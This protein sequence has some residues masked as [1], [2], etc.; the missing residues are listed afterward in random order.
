MPRRRAGSG[1][2][3]RARQAR[4]GLA[5]L[6]TLP[7]SRKLLLEVVEVFADLRRS[8]PSSHVIARAPR[9]LRAG[10]WSHVL[11]QLAVLE[12]LVDT[13]S[14]SR[15]D[16]LEA[17]N[18]LDYRMHTY[19]VLTYDTGDC[20][21]LSI[22]TRIEMVLR[23][24]TLDETFLVVKR[25]HLFRTQHEVSKAMYLD[26]HIFAFSM[27]APTRRYVSS[28]TLGLATSLRSLVPKI[29]VAP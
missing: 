17:Q 14:R 3:C 26:V 9:S 11:Q 20:E 25:Y 1:D 18:E 29:F 8:S 2:Q 5:R 7:D 6:P 19:L 22:A 15:E 21:L 23:C 24:Q 12:G 28:A 4:Q 10:V 27:I 16:W 13:N